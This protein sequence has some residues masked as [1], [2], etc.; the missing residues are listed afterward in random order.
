MRFFP[1]AALTV[2]T[3]AG[4]GGSVSPT[5]GGGAGTTGT[6]GTTTTSAA[7]TGGA[8]STSTAGTGGA[9]STSTSTASA[10]GS[11]GSTTSASGSTASASS[12]SGAGGA[13]SG[14]GDCSS[15]AQCPGSKCVE[16]FPGG[17]RVCADVLVEAKVCNH[18]GLDECCGSTMP[19]P[20]GQPCYP[21]PLEPFCD[22]QVV[23]HNQCAT[24]QC[25]NDAA[26]GA[27]NACLVAGVLGRKVRACFP[28]AC[29]H[30]SECT[31]AAGGECAPVADPCCGQATTLYCIYPGDCRSN[32]DCGN[33]FCVIDP[34]KMR[35]ACT[36]AAPLCPA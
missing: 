22:V 21:S 24:D 32:A 33:N 29:K 16:I 27:G 7:G 12:T 1:W 31:D 36:A 9:P 11:G 14:S 35:A 25:T 34:A 17:F 3:C 13:L 19:C 15:D 30:D 6:G 4:C 18:P 2:L 26:C 20:S 28:A 10:G 23:D 8:S 5:G